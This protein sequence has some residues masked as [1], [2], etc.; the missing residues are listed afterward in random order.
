MANKIL[1]K[2]MSLSK[3]MDANWEEDLINLNIWDDVCDL[4]YK[5]NTDM[6]KANVI[7]TYIVLAYGK[8][9]PR[10]DLNMDRMDNKVKILKS[11]AGLSAMSDDDYCK[12]AVGTL[13][14]Y[15]EIIEFYINYQKDRRFQEIVGAYDF[16]AKATATMNTSTDLREMAIAAQVFNSAVAL[17]EKADALVD[18]IEKENVH[19]DSALDKE[20]RTKLSDRR[21]DDFISHEIYMRSQSKGNDEID[22]SS[23]DIMDKYEQ[24]P[25]N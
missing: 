8:E 15:N 17:R 22:F 12:A 24:G 11:L 16:H 9:S 1:T 7:L 2:I 14:P 3:N 5:F 13:S 19:I 21:G 23:G 25:L 4:Y 10:L 20:N 6:H 18:Q